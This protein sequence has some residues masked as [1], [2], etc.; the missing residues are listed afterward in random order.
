MVA[1][2]NAD[3]LPELFASF[4]AATPTKRGYDIVEDVDSHYGPM[5][6]R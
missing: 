6:C 2:V 1:D 4:R 3:G 5:C